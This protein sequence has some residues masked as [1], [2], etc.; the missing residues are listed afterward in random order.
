MQT[1]SQRATRLLPVGTVP[2]RARFAVMAEPP[3]KE[4]QV[5]WAAL[6]A[7]A[8]TARG[9]AWA[10]YS[11]FAVG[12]AIATEDGAVVAGCN[13]EN[14]T[15]GLTLCA[16]RV[17]VAAAVAAGH[18]RPVAAVVV[19]DASP[20]APPCGPCLETFTEFAEDLPILLVSTSGERVQKRLRQ[21]LPEPFRFAAR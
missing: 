16:E 20:P 1:V 4:A 6:I 11:H 15:F 13:V 18:G 19:T 14:R 21:L 5:D 2:S 12:A 8:T 3:Q 17:A 7:A 10:P 9:H